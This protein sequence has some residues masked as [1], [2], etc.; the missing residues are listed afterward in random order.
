MSDHEYRS[1][2][3]F[4][5]FYVGEHANKTNRT[6]HFIG[7]TGALVCV[8]A[9]LLTKRRALLAVA[10][11]F[12]YGFAWVGHFFVE[13][14]KPASFKYPLWSF[15]GDLRMWAKTVAGTMDAEVERVMAQPQAEPA[16]ADASATPPAQAVDRS[17]N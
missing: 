5:P 14:N 8:G 11:I 17:M 3:E 1:F 4:W 9:A 15:R 7:T 10:P 6:L 12:G 2:E 16:A 13:K